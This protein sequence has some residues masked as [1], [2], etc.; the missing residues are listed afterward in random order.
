MGF[1]FTRKKDNSALIN[2]AKQKFVTNLTDYLEWN[3]KQS[4]QYRVIVEKT[5]DA[6]V[7]SFSIKDGKIIADIGY[8]GN[9]FEKADNYINQ[10][11]KDLSPKQFKEF[12]TISLYTIS[13]LET[14]CSVHANCL[15]RN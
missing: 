2:N 11:L 10:I 14:V 7:D 3:K 12:Q 9:N 8:T 13:Y 1:S 5:L 15:L 4:K 6:T